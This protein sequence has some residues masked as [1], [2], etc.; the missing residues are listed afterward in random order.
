MIDFLWKYLDAVEAANQTYASD[1]SFSRHNRFGWLASCIPVGNDVASW[2]CS[3]AP[4]DGGVIDLAGQWRFVTDPKDLGLQA[5]FAKADFD[6]AGWHRIQAGLSVE[7]QGVTQD[8]SLSPFDS[9]SGAGGA[10]GN[11]PYNGYMWYRTRMY[12]PAGWKAGATLHIGR[13]QSWSWIYVNGEPVGEFTE[14]SGKPSEDIHLEIPAD[15]LKPGA[16]NTIAI[17]LYNIENAGGLNLPPVLLTDGR[18][19][20]FAQVETT[21]GA[22]LYRTFEHTRDGQTG[23][24]AMLGSILSPGAYVLSDRG[25]LVLSDWE[26]RDRT[27]PNRLAMMVGGQ[28]LYADLGEVGA[29]YDAATDGRMSA[30]WIL[31]WHDVADS[32]NPRPLLVLLDNSA[33]RMEVTQGLRRAAKRPHRHAHPH[34]RR[35]AIPPLR[36]GPPVRRPRHRAGRAGQG[37]TGGHPAVVQD[38][39]P[40]P[41]EYTELYKPS[42]DGADVRLLYDYAL[43][44]DAFNTEPLKVAPAPMLHSLGIASKTPGLARPAEAV[45]LVSGGNW[46]GYW[47]L[48]NADEI[49]LKVPPHA[50]KLWRGGSTTFMGKKWQDVFKLMA[51]WGANCVRCQIGFTIDW[52]L[53]LAKTLAGPLLWED[54]QVARL[55]ENGPGRQVRRQHDHAE[56][57][58]GQLP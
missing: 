58:L 21:V 20:Q 30:A 10:G 15:K 42:A 50:A 22:C 16:A 48:L 23:R 43:I 41:V 3:I 35:P 7:Y 56:P 53:P 32:K 12:V 4:A 26:L 51:S 27:P 19:D 9:P 5:G 37:R 31:I 25:E 46:G 38:H 2:E 52:D 24:T 13:A 47:G 34:L 1:P 8:N 28:L 14:K 54:K 55:D 17:R 39:A 36:P 44:K 6:D 40:Y 29:A 45:E 18:A 57:F 33:Q 11:K 49:R